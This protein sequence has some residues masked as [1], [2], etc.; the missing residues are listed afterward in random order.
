MQLNIF[1]NWW[2]LTIKGVLLLI[3]G[4]IA[5]FMPEMT[6]LVLMTYFGALV[7][8]GG[9]FILAAVIFRR[10]NLGRG[11]G[12]VLFEALLDIAIGLLVLFNP[13]I[14]VQVFVIILAA[15][16]IFAGILQVVYALQIRQ[17]QA[18]WWMPLLNGAI[19]AALGLFIGFNP[20]E[21]SIALI[22]I[23]GIASVFF[24]LML[25]F[26]SLSLRNSPSV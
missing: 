23:V 17:A 6:L 20:A 2:L 15:W 5:L 19:T 13:A 11:W 7:L 9:L 12:W 14:T 16:L 26:T 3:L 18:S 4:L 1:N 21:G 10:K 24:G 8:L 22:Y 25:I